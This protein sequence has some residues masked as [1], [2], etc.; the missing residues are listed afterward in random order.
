M[1]HMNHEIGNQG[2]LT[3]EQAAAYLNLSPATLHTW[4]CTKRH[5]LP[6][7]KVGNRYVRYNRADLD[8]FIKTQ[9]QGAKEV[10]A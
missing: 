3:T 9:T 2:L 1:N 7:V 8:A 5:V 6:Y 10:A 4:R